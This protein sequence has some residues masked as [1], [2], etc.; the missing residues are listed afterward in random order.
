MLI[1]EPETA[2]QRIFQ[3]NEPLRFLAGLVLVTFLIYQKDHAARKT[4]M[5]I[6]SE[7]RAIII[8]ETGT[9]DYLQSLGT[10]LG[11][12]SETAKCQLESNGC[13]F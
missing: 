2:M 8:C 13:F 9:V 5:K 12:N 7:S 10:N 4:A 3:D 1:R 11:S 6:P